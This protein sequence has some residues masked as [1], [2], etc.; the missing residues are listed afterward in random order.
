[1]AVLNP[2]KVTIK[3]YPND[4]TEELV[5]KNHPQ[6]EEM[7][8]R[9]ITFS[10]EIWVEQDDFMEDPPKKFFRLGP[11]REVRLRYAYLITC[12]ESGFRLSIRSCLSCSGFSSLNNRS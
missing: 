10:K 2:L 5:A 3:N 1:M 8:T 12:R 7:G 11:G 4:Q 6:K 9:S